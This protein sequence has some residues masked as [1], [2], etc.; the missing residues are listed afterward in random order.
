[1]A[2]MVTG[3]VAERVEPKMRHSRRVNFSPSRPR[4]DQIYTRTLISARPLGAAHPMPTA[5]MKVPKK[6]KVRMTPKFRKKFSFHQRCLRVAL[7]CFSSYPEFRMIG[8]SRRLKKRVCL[9][10]CHQLRSYSFLTSISRIKCPGESLMINPTT[11]PAKIET[12]V[13]CTALIR[14]IWR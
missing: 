11:I 3:S 10:D 5:E 9:N 8:G 13:S 1:M 2:R 4:K 14:L 12:T 6:A 7:T